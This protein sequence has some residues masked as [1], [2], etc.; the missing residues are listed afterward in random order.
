MVWKAGMKET[1]FTKARFERHL[2]IGSFGGSAWTC[3]KCGYYPGPSEVP[4]A[5]CFN[6]GEELQTT[7]D[8]PQGQEVVV[9]T[10]AYGYRRVAIGKTQN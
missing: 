1:W 6:C 7:A 9:E 3:Q 5:K 2:A 8:D 4:H 10:T